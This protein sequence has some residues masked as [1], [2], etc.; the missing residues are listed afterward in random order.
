MTNNNNNGKKL[1]QLR[2]YIGNVHFNELQ[3]FLSSKSNSYF[4]LSELYLIS[5]VNFLNV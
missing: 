4:H 3:K 5:Q 2:G 1:L